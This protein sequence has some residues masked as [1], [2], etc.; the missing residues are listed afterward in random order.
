MVIQ[1]LKLRSGMIELS[2]N[3]SKKLFLSEES[4]THFSKIELKN[5]IFSSYKKYVLHKKQLFEYGD[6]SFYRRKNKCDALDKCLTYID[7]FPEYK[8][9]RI[10]QVI[11]NISND[12]EHILPSPGNSSYSPQKE[13]LKTLISISQQYIQSLHK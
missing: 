9:S 5:Y 4:A 11:L 2:I 10:C 8:I 12:L 3:G 1:Q 7:L 13:K 6:G